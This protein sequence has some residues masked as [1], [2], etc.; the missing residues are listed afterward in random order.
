MTS[1]ANVQKK[2]LN[3]VR[4]LVFSLLAIVLMYFA[5]R[6]VKFQDLWAGVKET[7]F[8]WVLASVLI[9]IA[10]Y[11]FRA[12]R[13]QILIEPIGYKPSFLNTYNAVM[14]GYLAN[15]AVPRIGEVTR[16]GILN[17]TDKIPFD[18]LIGTVIFER[19]F[20]LLFLILAIFV[21][22]L[23]RIDVFGEFIFDKLG[24]AFTSIGNTLFSSYST[25][26]I[27]LLIV[28]AFIAMVY[29]FRDQLRNFGMVKKVKSL[30]K[31][32]WEGLKSGLR[33]KH[34]ASF[35]LYSL[36]I[37]L[38]YWMMSYTL[39]LAIPETAHL[40]VIDAFFLFVLGSLG[41]LIPVPGGFGAFHTIVPAGLMLVYGI[42]EKRGIIFATISHESQVLFMLILGGIALASVFLRQKKEKNITTT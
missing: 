31:G 39:M 35:L 9:G 13:W 5:F 17:K 37:T 2:T 33:M 38:C 7:R 24:Q 8:G 42:E 12:A 11:L 21:V 36:L 18:R 20:D 40:T 29:F 34:R 6:G 15:L 25:I 14:I 4:Y 23:I 22:I 28:A 26:L 27:T 10:A 19:I 30:A 3:I 16:C 32:F 1:Q 41:W